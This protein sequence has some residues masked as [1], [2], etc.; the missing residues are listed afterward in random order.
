[1]PCRRRRPPDAAAPPQSETRLKVVALAGG[2]GAARLLRGLLRA[3]PPESVTALVNTGD[4]REFYGVHVSPDIDIVT[5]ARGSASYL[6]WHRGPTHGPLG[7]IGLGL[8]T[9]TLVWVGQRAYDR[10][11]APRD[12]ASPSTHQDPA[13]FGMLVALSDEAIRLMG[14]AAGLVDIK[15]CAID[16]T[17]SALKFVHRHGRT[18]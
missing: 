16:T 5:L 12:A 4:D 15:V 10:W 6:K 7:I 3:V 11:R 1:M 9:A 17:W 13:S 8:V 2:V 14:L 18:L